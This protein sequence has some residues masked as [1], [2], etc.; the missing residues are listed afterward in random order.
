MT[1]RNWVTCTCWTS[2]P[3][4]S[5]Y[6]TDEVLQVYPSEAEARAALRNAYWANIQE[7]RTDRRDYP[8]WCIG[9]GVAP[10]PEGNHMPQPTPNSPDLMW[11]DH[12]PQAFFDLLDA[13]GS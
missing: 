8:E 6:D 12:V 1:N 4:L 3:S 10:E 7:I 5:G 11:S 13:E 9:V 2:E